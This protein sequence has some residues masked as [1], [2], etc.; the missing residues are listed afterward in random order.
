[1]GNMPIVQKLLKDQE[2]IMRTTGLMPKVQEVHYS[3]PCTYE[4]DF[5]GHSGHQTRSGHGLG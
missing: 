2:W 1:M 3:K 4:T 5:N